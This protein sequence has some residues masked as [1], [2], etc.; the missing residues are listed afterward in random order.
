MSSETTA[1]PNTERRPNRRRTKIV[2]KSF[3]FRLISLLAAIWAAN[4][5]F[6][7]AIFYFYQEHLLTF[8]DLFPRQGTRPAVPL[9]ALFPISI[10]CAFLFGLAMVVILGVY[11]THHIAG[12]LYRLKV[13]LKRL[14]QGDFNFQIK[15]RDRDFL[16]DFPGYFNTTLNHL[17]TQALGDIEALRSIEASLNNPSKAAHMV[18]QLR[19][20]KET[21]VQSPGPAPS[22]VPEP[23]PV[24]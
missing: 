1:N 13:S 6:T 16:L 22:P 17:K 24:H 10:A 3:Q 20:K 19:E 4:S 12:P 7:V 15:F 14:A 23:Q 9:H 5:A 18:R 2:D 21:L 11:L 8:Y